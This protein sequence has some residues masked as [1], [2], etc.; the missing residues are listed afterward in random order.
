MQ[1]LKRLCFSCLRHGWTLLA[2]SI[3]LLAT[4]VTLLRFGL[5]YAEG[6]KTDIEL[7]IAERYG[8]QVQIGQLSAGWQSGGPALLLQQV[9]VTDSQQLP[10]LQIDE[11]R[12]RLDFWGSLRRLT[13]TAEHFELSGLQFTNSIVSSY[14]NPIPLLPVADTEPLFSAVEQLLFRQLKNFTLVDSELTAAK[15]IYAGYCHCHQTAA[16]AQ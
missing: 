7:L 12:V 2:L 9:Q 3:V 11:T 15:S 14:Y 13:L 8:A 10:V 6:Y 5:P 1:K 16:L 4:V